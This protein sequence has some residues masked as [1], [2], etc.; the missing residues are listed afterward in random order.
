MNN[1]DLDQIYECMIGYEE[2]R[3]KGM[4]DE[5]IEAGEVP[6]LEA[7]LNESDKKSKRRLR[8]ISKE[9]KES[10][11]VK[12]D[13]D[14]CKAIQSRSKSNFDSMISNLEAKYAHNGKAATKKKTKTQIQIICIYFCYYFK[15]CLHASINN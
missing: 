7:F 15:S 5:M 14:L 11:A 9:E 12:V 13:D 3:I 2:D 10:K 4:I 1:G 6:G 8:K